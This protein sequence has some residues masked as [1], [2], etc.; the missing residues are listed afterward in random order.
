MDKIQKEIRDQAIQSIESRIPDFAKRLAKLY[1]ADNWTWGLCEEEH[2]PYD[3]EI[4]DTLFELVGYLKEA[5]EEGGLFD[6]WCTA[7]GGLA[8][9]YNKREIKIGFEYNIAVVI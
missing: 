9:H 6:G 4:K 5:I 7:T 1:Q 3:N 2:I 8:I